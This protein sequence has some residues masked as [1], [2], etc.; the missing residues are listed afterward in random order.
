[1]KLTRNIWI[2]SL[3]I[4]SS[5]LC[6]L[7]FM[8]NRSSAHS[9]QEKSRRDHDLSGVFRKHQ[10]I[11]LDPVFTAQ[12]VRSTGHISLVSP[13]GT[14]DLVLTPN[15]M[16]AK[17]YRAEETIE[18]GATRTLPIRPVRTY[19]GFVSGI[20]GAV[21]RL[22]IDETTF[23]GLIRTDQGEYFVEPASRYSTSAA[24]DDYVLYEAKDV[25]KDTAVS[26]GWTL[27][28]K[29]NDAIENVS[30][31]VDA[32][33]APLPLF[34]IELATEAD[35]EY[36]TASGGTEAA[37]IE[38]LDIMNVV[39]VVYRQELGLTFVIT[40]QHAWATADPFNNSTQAAL[41]TSFRD[42]WNLAFTNI[43]RDVTHLWSGSSVINLSGLT[44][45][46]SVCNPTTT[47]SAYGIRGRVVDVPQKFILSAHELGHSLGAPAAHPDT[48]PGCAGTIMASSS[49]PS[50]VL[51]F[52]PTSRTSINTF[53]STHTSCLTAIN[54]VTRFDFDGDIRADLAVFRPSTGYWYI[55]NSATGGLT[56]LLFGQL[57]DI[58]A[59]EDFD[60][61][62][63][64]DPAVFRPSSGVWY[65]Q[66]SRGGFRG[67]QFGANGDRPVAGDYDGDKNADV[68][69]YRPSTGAWYISNSNN[70]SFTGLFFGAIGDL[71]AP[72]D[73]DGDGRFDIAVFR[74]STGTFYIQQSRNGFRVEQFGAN[75]DRPAP[76]DFD[77]DGKADVTIFR[78]STGTWYMLPSTPGSNFR[79][80]TFGQNG[81]APVPA[82]YDGDG[83]ADIGVWR[84]DGGFWYMLNS[85]GGSFGNG[86]FRSQQ[87]GAS[88]DIPAP[89][90]YVSGP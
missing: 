1:M 86:S 54:A 77:G 63:R 2:I 79:F 29:V 68:A 6:A 25:I 58:A 32:V 37:N 83:N 7:I 46:G 90:A 61:D 82:D 47:P 34:V 5:G 42:H 40:F 39:D 71:P 15:D 23:E 8:T 30:T 26:C 65:M 64:S 49:G 18:G 52:C 33:A 43:N 80:K 73:Y 89:S 85:G 48:A 53:V 69:V 22:S 66:Q 87:F 44:F 10:L 38:I 51:T 50:S 57:G 24:A 14:F 21:A 9:A 59:P 19:K 13:T 11:K 55:F 3:V 28:Q 75:G 84:P 20:D 36:V 17:G 31:R 88:G 78:P 45:V 81:D 67:Q 27:D 76:A 41:L 35:N 56:A 72:A 12:K 70:G 16:R 62:G 4:V 60:G 74:P